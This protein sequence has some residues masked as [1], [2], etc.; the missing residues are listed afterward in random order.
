MWVDSV[1]DVNEETKKR[2]WNNYKIIIYL[3]KKQ[4]NMAN[5]LE[6]LYQ[7]VAGTNTCQC[8]QYCVNAAQNRGDIESQK[9]MKIDKLFC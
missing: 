8:F 2:K 5:D 3:I 7:W 1:G 9:Y 4:N 6:F